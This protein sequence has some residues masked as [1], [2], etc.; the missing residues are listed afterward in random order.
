MDICP[1]CFEHMDMMGYQD[2]RQN[3]TECYKLDCGHAYHTSCIITCLTQMNRKCPQCNSQKDPSKELTKEALASKL[4]RELKRDDRVK[5]LMDEFKESYDE[6]STTLSQFKKDLKK[7]VESHAQELCLEEKR[8]YM[9]KCISEIQTT[10][11][12]IARQKGTQYQGA[13]TPMRNHRDYW[14]GTGFEQVFFGRS[15]SRTIHRLKYPHLY[16]NLY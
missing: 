10:S 5:P 9:M 4:I 2:E 14:N 16:L 11:K 1:L 13:L 8:K 7:F 3:T 15:M 6:Y 12:A